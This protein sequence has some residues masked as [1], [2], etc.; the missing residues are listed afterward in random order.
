[1]TEN[2]IISLCAL[3]NLGNPI[4][5]PI[6]IF[7]GLCHKIYKIDTDVGC[8]AIKK[9]SKNV[10]LFDEKI[11]N[12]YELTEEIAEDFYK[13]GINSIVSKKVNGKHVALIED[14]FFMVYPFVDGQALPTEIVS[15][16]HAEKIISEVIK[17]HKLNLNIDGLENPEFHVYLKEE[18]I[19]LVNVAIDKNCSFSKLLSNNLEIILELNDKYKTETQYFKDD[20]VISHTDL[21]QKNVLWDNDQN[22]VLIDWESAKKINK[23]LDIISVSLD[24]SGIITNDF[25][26]DLFVELLKKYKQSGLGLNESLL[27]DAFFVISGN[28]LNWIF[29]NIKRAC[30]DDDLEEKRL[31]ETEVSKCLPIIFKLLKLSKE[32]FEL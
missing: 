12:N 19:E 21:D 5:K 28:W 10:N 29:F 9:L 7:G 22:P 27:K 2:I 16:E 11:R 13:N 20:L 26:K 4:S 14:R 6:R 23:T 25:D 15:K 3:F 18:I 1:M 32:A 24:W 30:S 8:F 17:I 31:G